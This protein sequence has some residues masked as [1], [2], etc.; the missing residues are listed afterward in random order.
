MQWRDTNFSLIKD[1][2]LV[3]D[4]TEW[5]YPTITGAPSVVIPTQFLFDYSFFKKLFQS[6]SANDVAFLF[7]LQSEISYGCT[8]TP[9]SWSQYI[10]A[11][12]K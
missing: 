5:N 8:Y 1:F 12:V 3:N 11:Y 2:S 7:K 9:F 10:M 4:V 6:T